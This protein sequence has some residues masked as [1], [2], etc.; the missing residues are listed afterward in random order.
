MVYR[1]YIEC[2]YARGSCMNFTKE[3]PIEA[4]GRYEKK[5]IQGIYWTDNYNPPRKLNVA[6]GISMST[7]CP[8]LDLAPKTSFSIPVLNRITPG[9][10]LPSGV[11]QL[12]YRYKSGEGLTTDWSPLSNLV[13]IYDATDDSPFC[14]IIGTEAD[15]VTKI[16]KI[17]GKR[18]EWI[19]GQLDTSFELIELAALYKKDKHPLEMMKYFRLQ[20]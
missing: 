15:M 1:S 18:I 3:H 16:G 2:V 5:D 6:S 19:I 7:P 10:Q 13:P 8:F 4:I 12:T 17:T 9:G 11:Y 20:N 14:Q